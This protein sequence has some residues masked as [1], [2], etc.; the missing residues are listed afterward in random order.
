MEQKNF[1]TLKEIQY[2]EKE[3]LKTVVS[4]FDEN[5]MN[6]FIWA[7]TFLGAVR[8]KG[9]IPWDDDIDLAMT[10][11]EYNKFIDYLKKHDFKISDNLEVI[12]LELNN[13]DFPLLKIINK[14]IKVDEEEKCDEYLWIDI[15]PLDATPEDNRKFYKRVRFLH[16]IFIL[17]RQQQKKMELMAANKFK[18]HIK[19]IFMSI[20]KLW[21]YDSYIR[22]YLKYCTKYNYDDYDFVHNNVWTDSPVIYNKEELVTTKYQFEDLNVNG[23]VDYHKY[24]SE[25]YGEDYMQLPPEEKRVTHNFK[26]WKVER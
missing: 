16:K 21:N 4:F 23:L 20:L 26:A 14:N 5:D 17:K 12:G 18:K 15:F 7:G 25:G 22:F 13:S 1:L 8:H 24:L 11:P 2:E 3:M 19:N 9:F 10:R 6:Y